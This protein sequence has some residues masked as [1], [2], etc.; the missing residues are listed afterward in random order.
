[1]SDAV[2]VDPA[3]AQ[4]F[5]GTLIFLAA[6]VGVA[7]YIVQSRLKARSHAEELKRLHLSELRRLELKRVREKLDTCLGPLQMSL[8]EMLNLM[9][10]AFMPMAAA[11]LCYGSQRECD[12]HYHHLDQL[13]GGKVKKYYTESFTLDISEYLVRGERNLLPSFVGPEV[14]EMIRENPDSDI[15]DIY[16]MTCRRML[17]VCRR[18]SDLINKYAGH[19]FQLQKI[20]TYVAEWPA[21]ANAIASRFLMPSQIM[22]FTTELEDIVERKWA[23]GDYSVLYPRINK[24]PMG[25]LVYCMKQAIAIRKRETELGLADHASFEVQDVLNRI[26]SEVEKQKQQTSEYTSAP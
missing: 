10:T 9:S 18:A 25:G 3:V 8:S 12:M 15:A 14:E 20:D 21:C 26:T 6:C 7:G 11:S 16:F 1:M 19:L 13:T 17:R 23:Q 24:F 4:I 22:T 2:G 5:Q